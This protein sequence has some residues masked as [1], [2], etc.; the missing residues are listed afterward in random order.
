MYNMWHPN[1]D[2]NGKKTLER[3]ESVIVGRGCLFEVSG[4]RLKVTWCH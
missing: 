3:E 2:A 1:C 4:K